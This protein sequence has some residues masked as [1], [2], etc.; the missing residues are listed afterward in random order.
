LTI[1]FPEPDSYLRNI[2][3]KRNEYISLIKKHYQ[4]TES[5]EDI[6]LQD[7][8][9]RDVIRTHPTHFFQVYS[10]ALVQDSLKRV[11]F[12]WSKENPNISFFQGLPDLISPFFSVFLANCFGEMSDYQNGFSTN[13][14]FHSDLE[15]C[16]KRLVSVEADAYWCISKLMY[17][18]QHEVPFTKALHAE[19]MVSQF[20]EVVLKVNPQIVDI[21]ENKFNIDFVMFTFRWHHCFMARELSFKNLI[22]LWDYYLA[23][24]IKGFTRL[25]LYFA[26]VYLGE[27]EPYLKKATDMS[28][29]M[30]FFQTPPFVDWDRNNIQNLVRR[31]RDLWFRHENEH[32]HHIVR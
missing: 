20:R 22:I 7:S 18:L 28:E 14:R 2:L 13:T 1:I 12:I 32:A 15:Q 26:A 9:T 5:K 23:E 21:I 6:S 27:F 4:E 10:N 16:M 30:L 3:G 8:I 24:G 17:G 19:G 25:Q 29:C 11:S 31:A